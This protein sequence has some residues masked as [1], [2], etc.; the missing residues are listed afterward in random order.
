M[1]SSQK[2]SP[3]S[4]SSSNAVRGEPDI[5]ADEINLIDYFRV[6]WKRRYFIV[7]G[8][9]LPALIVGLI[10]FLRPRRSEPMKA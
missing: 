6:L 7:L 4:Q 8:S 5:Y 3:K 2:N 1:T 10:L 9:V